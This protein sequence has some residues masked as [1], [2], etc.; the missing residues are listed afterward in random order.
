MGTVDFLMFYCICF[1]DRV[2]FFYLLNKITE[3][4]LPLV[5]NDGTCLVVH[6]WVKISFGNATGHLN[7]G[8]KGVVVKRR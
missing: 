3:G 4:L 2:N 6:S 5:K 1:V 8:S 7:D